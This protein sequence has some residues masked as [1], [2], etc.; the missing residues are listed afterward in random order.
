MLRFVSRICALLVL[1]V[2]VVFAAAAEAKLKVAFVTSESGMGDRSFN[3][4]MDQGMK[5]AVKELGI[6]YVIIQPRSISA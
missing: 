5:R 2:G 3:D 6:E 1:A 4:M